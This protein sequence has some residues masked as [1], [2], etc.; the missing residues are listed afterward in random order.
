M[1]IVVGRGMP[2]I[3]SFDICVVGAGAGGLSLASN[4]LNKK[5]SVV[6]VESGGVGQRPS[7]YETGVV[8]ERG[9][10]YARLATSRLRGFGGSTQALGWGGLCKPLDPQD[11]EARPWVRDS[12]WPFGIEQ[13]KH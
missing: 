2:D 8:P 4:F 13:M 5:H 3:L 10:A 11:F 12:G 1:S 9:L 7:P 6:V